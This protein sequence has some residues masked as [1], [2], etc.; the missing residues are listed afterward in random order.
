MNIAQSTK[1]AES[2]PILSMLFGTIIL[3]LAASPVHAQQLE[4]IVVTATKRQAN[5]RDVPIS[6]TTFDQEELKNRTATRLT[7]VT[8]GAANVSLQ[9]N[10]DLQSSTS[11]AIRGL[12][13]TLNNTGV[14]PGVGLYIDG[15]YVGRNIAFDAALAD[16]AQV[17]IMRGPQGTLFGKNTIQGAINVITARPTEDAETTIGFQLGN[18]DLRQIRAGTGGALSDNLL[19]KA[20]VYWRERDGYVDN[21]GVGGNL[22]GEDYY[23]GRAQLLYQPSDN[24]EVY[25]TVDAQQDDT[26]ANTRATGSPSLTVQTNGLPGGRMEFFERDI[27]GTSLQIDYA[28]E[29]SLLTSITGYRSFDSKF[30]NDQDFS[31]LLFNLIAQR[32]ESADQ[33]TQEFRLASSGDNSIDWLVGLYLFRQ[34]GDTRSFAEFGADA[35]PLNGLNLDAPVVLDVDSY[36]VFGDLTFNLTDALDLSVG[37]R[38]TAEEQD[39]KFDQDSVAPPFQFSLTDSREDDDISASVSLT[40]AWNNDLSTYARYARGFKSGGFN[41]TFVLNPAQITSFKPETL[42]SFEVGL[43]G[44]FMDRTLRLN[45]AVYYLDYDDKQ[46]SVFIPE[47]F[48]FSFQNAATIESIGAELDLTAVPTDWLLLQLAAGWN[49]GEFDQFVNCGGL[50]VDCD[51]N[52]LTEPSITLSGAVQATWEATTNTEFFLRLDARYEDSYFTDAQ[53]TLEADN[54]T[55]VNARFALR[56]VNRSWEVALWSTN[57]LDEE[58]FSPQPHPFFPDELVSNIFPPRSYGL[59]VNFAF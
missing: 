54:R 10:V 48:S 3:G 38:W 37:L 28:F 24:L 25:F 53:N 12:R 21:I 45:T 52:E 30:A 7:D 6:V 26:S 18:D 9:Q 29:N 32:E 44:D 56:Q 19:G 16:V 59:E 4:E 51:G 39:L 34:Q 20:Y 42:D 50:G 15:V 5:L 11:F 43:K 58:F 33:V 49:D 41:T 55:L 14:T 40:Y 2:K 31:P 46:Q 27:F 57:L 23:G 1:R 13:T 8:F 35:G 17:E 22:N 47:A 36:A